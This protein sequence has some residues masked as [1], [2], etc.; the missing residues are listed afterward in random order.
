MKISKAV[1]KRNAK[2]PG[3]FSACSRCGG[4]WGWKKEKSHPVSKTVGIFLFCEECDKVVT[5][6]E[7]WAALDEWKLKCIQQTKS[8]ESAKKIMATEF[9]EWPREVPK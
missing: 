5:V 1:K 4:N 9:L 6:K 2:H 3:P 7:R 8:L